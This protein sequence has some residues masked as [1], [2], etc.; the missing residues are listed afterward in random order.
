MHYV[1]MHVNHMMSENIVFVK[2]FNQNSEL[3]WHYDVQHQT[4]LKNEPCNSETCSALPVKRC[5]AAPRWQGTAEHAS[6]VTDQNPAAKNDHDCVSACTSFRAPAAERP[7][8]PSGATSVN[9]PH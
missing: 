6:S 1:N 4:L 8:H 3:H 5:R 2:S 9:H 7:R